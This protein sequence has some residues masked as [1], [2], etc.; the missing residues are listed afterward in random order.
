MDINEFVKGMNDP[1]L[2][3]AITKLGNTPQGQNLLKNLT[4]EDKK[5]LMDK[6][7]KLSSNGITKDMLLHQLKNP[8]VISK[9]GSILNKKG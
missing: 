5:N 3:E 7:G 2:K 6:I 1:K 9:L 4:P 8:D